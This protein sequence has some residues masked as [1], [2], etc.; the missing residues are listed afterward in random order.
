VASDSD[1]VEKTVSTTQ[2]FDLRRRGDAQKYLLPT[3]RVVAG[4]DMLRFCSI[5]PSETV[6][7]GRDEGCELILHDTSVSRR[8]AVITADPSGNLT[9]T[10]LG[11][12]NGTSRNGETVGAKQST[13]LVIG[14]H[15]E[16]GN[17]TLRLDRL[18]LDELAH[19]NR[20]VER[21][22]LA[23]KDP[24]TG[25][26]TRLY[27]EEEL[28]SVVQRHEHARVPIAAAFIDVDHFKKVNDSFGHGVGDE[29]LRAVARIVALTVRDSDTTVRYG[30][31][32]LLVILPNCDEAGAHAM[33]ERVRAAIHRH[34]WSHYAETLRV[35]VS[36]GAA[37]RGPREPIKE[38]LQRADKALYAAKGGGRDRT[39]K[40][41]D[42][43]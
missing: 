21:L 26:A 13:P 38:W 16:V 43:A 7:I 19:L 29:V 33:A 36:C 42:I 11:S 10:D 40:A 2:T 30:G 18:G 12:T 22:D 25:L 20:V 28:P 23:N 9:L 4:P 32:E 35:T 31:E 14:D 3:L 5:Y 27:L 41:S 6:T 15:I 8:H 37:Q 24:L 34:T 39:C 17:I 1:E